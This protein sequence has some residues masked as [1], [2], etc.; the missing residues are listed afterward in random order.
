M[1]CFRTPF[2]AF[3]AEII[4]LAFFIQLGYNEKKMMRG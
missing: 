4:N 3:A 1:V 2:Y